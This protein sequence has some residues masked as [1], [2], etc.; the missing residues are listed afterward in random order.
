VWFINAR[1]TTIGVLVSLFCFAGLTLVRQLFFRPR[2]DSLK[3][4][5]MVS[6]V[7]LGVAMLGGA[8]AT[9]HRMQ[10]YTFGGSQHA[11]SNAVR[12]LQWVGARRAV[13]KN[14]IGVGMGT[15]LPDVGLTNAKG[16]VIVD[17]YWINLLVGVGPLGFIGFMGCIARIAWLGVMTFLRAKDDLEEWGGVLAISLLNFMIT[18]YVISFADNN[19]LVFTLAVAILALHRHQTKRIAS[20]PKARQAL[21]SPSTSLVRR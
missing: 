8:I 13:L 16:V 17:S 1:T 14:P 4:G 18:A 12:D 19:Y 20:E 21:P 7:L 11:G 6:L 3:S 9:S 15:P 2:G 10:M 5:I